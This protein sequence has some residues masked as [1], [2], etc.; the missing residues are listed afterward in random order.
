MLG[1]VA[2]R[3]DPDD[4]VVLPWPSPVEATLIPPCLLTSLA[5]HVHP[6]GHAVVAKFHVH[7]NGVDPVYM[8]SNRKYLVTSSKLLLQ[9]EEILKIRWKN[10][11]QNC[12][13]EL[14]FL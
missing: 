5:Y 6:A 12:N 3:Q 10:F 2:A 13:I 1:L 9:E 4:L 8:Q 7:V 11:S 14:L